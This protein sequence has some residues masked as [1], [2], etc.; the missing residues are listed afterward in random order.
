MGAK[1]K[2]DKEFINS[3]IKDYKAG[4]PY[5]ELT[6]KYKV[7]HPYILNWCI[8]DKAVRRHVYFKI[9]K[10]DVKDILELYSKGETQR[11]IARKYNVHQ[12]QI[13]NVIH[14]VTFKEEYKKYKFNSY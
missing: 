1:P 3:V 6:E 2:Y 4:I 5:N 12:K 13:F 8:K 14:G 7:K 9:K 10:E 11:N